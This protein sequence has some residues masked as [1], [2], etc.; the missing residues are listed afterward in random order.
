MSDELNPKAETSPQKVKVGHI[1]AVTHYVKVERI[2]PAAQALH[3]RD[4][5]TDMPFDI[6][7]DALIRRLGTADEF[8]R[9]EEVSQTEM[10]EQLIVSYGKVFSV[11]FEK[12]DGTK[13]T[14][15]GRLI[16]PDNLR[17]R[18]KVEDLDVVGGPEKRVRQVDHRTLSGLIV[19]GVCYVLKK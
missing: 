5:D 18:S 4:L 6:R 10:I 17:G 7:G 9:T 8:E 12:A 11:V 3:V 1:L 15:R 19:D 13:R 2:T 14:L 16:A